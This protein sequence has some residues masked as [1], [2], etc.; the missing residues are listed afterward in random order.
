MMVNRKFT[1]KIERINKKQ[2]KIYTIDTLDNWATPCW[3]KCYGD[4][5]ICIEL[6]KKLCGV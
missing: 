2:F 6:Y 5:A 3:F 1:H 4:D